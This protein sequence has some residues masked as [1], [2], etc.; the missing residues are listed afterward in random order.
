MMKQYFEEDEL[1]AKFQRGEIN[2]HGYVTHHSKEWDE[3]YEEFCRDNDFDPE[4]EAAAELF[5]DYKTDQ[6][7]AGFDEG[8]V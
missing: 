1:V 5:M 4:E 7:N 3:E 6:L 8:N 2:M